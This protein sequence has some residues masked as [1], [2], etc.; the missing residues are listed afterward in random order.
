MLPR[1]Q[2]ARLA[3]PRAPAARVPRCQQLRFQSTTTSSSSSGGGSATS[4]LATSF[5]GGLAGAAIFYAAYSYTPAGRT[6]STVNKAVTEAA[7]KYELAAKKLQE[8][9]P[10]ADQAV[11]SIK[12]FA[13]SYV[14]WI[15]GGR[16]YVDLAFKDWEAV[17]KNHAGE[18][19]QIVNDAYKKLQ[20]ISKKGLSLDTASQALDVLADF[21]KRL[22]SL[23]ADAFSDVVDNHPQVK[24]KF[25]G[26]IDQLKQLGERYG[27]EAK[28][29][30][31]ETWDEV[32]G[33]LAG[34]FTVANA[35]KVRKLIED[36]VQQ[37]K[38]LGDDAWKKALEEA[39]P[40][41]DKNP[42]AKELIEQNADKLKEGNVKELFEKAKAAVDSDK[43]E[44]LENYV[45]STVKNDDFK[46]LYD[47][48]QSAVKSGSTEDL[49]E[50]VK[51]AAKKTGSKD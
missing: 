41:L 7:K 12:Q 25:G 29:K 9:T 36:K 47:K 23:S 4:H 27:P 26:S 45:K 33:V 46:D 5:A 1:R 39:K 30:A 17:R 28:K 16:E 18:A 2:V 31:D 8:N 49:Q 37:L 15:P 51:V 10:S 34:G 13:Y 21:S 11:D 50:Y 19:D 22:A 35:D 32:K 42:K 38:K 43:I 48:V 20:G 24:E 6:A 44:D 14:A 3:V 40:V